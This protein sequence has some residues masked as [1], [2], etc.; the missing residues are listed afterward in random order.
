[1][2]RRNFLAAA[3]ASL[4]AAARADDP[5]PPS[6]FIEDMTWIELRD[7]VHAGATTA[8]VPTGGSEANGPQL[9]IG[10]HNLIVRHCA[11]AIA[12]RLGT[13]LVAP[14][15][16]YVPEGN[17]DPPDGN[18]TLPGTIGVSEPTFAAILRDAATSLALAGMKTICF[19]GDHGLSQRTQEAVA[20]S[21]TQAWRGRGIRVANLSRY[22]AAN[23]ESEWLAA[24]GFAAA[25]IGDHAGLLDTAELMAAEP[26]AVR[27]ALLSPKAWPVG[28]TGASGDPSLATA[29]IGEQLLE[30]K[31]ATGVAEIRAVLAAAR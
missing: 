15:L 29:A 1:M 25:Q 2:R 27:A 4:A 5:A 17:F 16:A 20:A 24:H 12:R 28:V 21:L 19:L 9:A 3:A 18:M 31:I 7:A 8:L 30:L 10:K 22:Y 6:P 11:A 26:A 14:V 23:G 13:V